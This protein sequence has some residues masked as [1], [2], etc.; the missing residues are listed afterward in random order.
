[1]CKIIFNDN[2]TIKKY[3]DGKIIEYPCEFYDNYANTIDKMNKSQEWK[4]KGNGA[5]FRGEINEAEKI[6][7]KNS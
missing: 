4:N 6:S 1:M 7:L 2:L 3:Q 5:I